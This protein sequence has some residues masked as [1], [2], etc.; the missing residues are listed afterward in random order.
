M[1]KVNLQYFASTREINF[2]KAIKDI[3]LYGTALLTT[4]FPIENSQI[5][6]WD[7]SRK[8]FVFIG[9]YPFKQE[10]FLKYEHFQEKVVHLRVRRIGAQQ[11]LPARP[12]MMREQM[13]SSAMEIEDS[14]TKNEKRVKERSIQEVIDK[15]RMWR[16]LYDALDVYGKK[17]HTLET[18]AR[19]VGI[20]KKTLDD[21]FLHLRL[22]EKHRFDF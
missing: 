13:S 20:A 1:L 5:F 4:G 14:N 18:A 16:R 7:Y 9:N 8:M 17:I 11:E 12:E 21:Y 15:V 6:Y 22:A 19:E 2:S 3:A 10:Y